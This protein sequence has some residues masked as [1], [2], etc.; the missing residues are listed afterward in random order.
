MASAA[1]VNMCV[2]LTAQFSCVMEKVFVKVGD[3]FSANIANYRFHYNKTLVYLG[4]IR[5]RGVTPPP[6][7]FAFDAETLTLRV[8]HRGQ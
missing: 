2:F 7:N 8:V 3:L 4:V 1:Q 6:V 5:W